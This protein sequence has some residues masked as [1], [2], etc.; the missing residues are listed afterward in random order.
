MGARG[1]AMMDVKKR[2]C[3]LL[4]FNAALG[5]GWKEVGNGTEKQDLGE[6]TRE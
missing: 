6:V 2:L 4:N 3:R 1:R 5:F